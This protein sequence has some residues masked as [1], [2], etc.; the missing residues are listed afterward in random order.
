M[1]DAFEQ[2]ARTGNRPGR[3]RT[4]EQHRL[5]W[6]FSWWGLFQTTLK[7]IT[8]PILPNALGKYK[9]ELF[10]IPLAEKPYFLF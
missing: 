1:N 2:H 7:P 6:V 9:S 8:L 4:T 5:E 10:R 3:R